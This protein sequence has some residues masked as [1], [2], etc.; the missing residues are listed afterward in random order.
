MIAGFY[1]VLPTPAF[2]QHLFKLPG[3]YYQLHSNYPEPNNKELTEPQKADC[4]KGFAFCKSS[5][6]FC[7]RI[8]PTSNWL[9]PFLT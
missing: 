8:N 2:Y 6:Y 4:V 3:I 7:D 5:P 1:F 9:L